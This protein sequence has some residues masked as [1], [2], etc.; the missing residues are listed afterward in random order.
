MKKPPT[1]NKATSDSQRGGTAANSFRTPSLMHNVRPDLTDDDSESVTE[2]QSSAVTHQTIETLIQTMKDSKASQIQKAW[3]AHSF[4]KNLDDSV[5]SRKVSQFKEKRA[6]KMIND[7]VGKYLQKKEQQ[8]EEA[9]S[10][11]A[12]KF[13]DLMVAQHQRRIF[14]ALRDH[15]LSKKYMRKTSKYSDTFMSSRAESPSDAESPSSTSLTTS[16]HRSILERTDWREIVPEEGKYVM[17]AKWHKQR[18]LARYF[19]FLALYKDDLL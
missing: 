8:K 14:K 11:K 6:A 17:A 12:T 9:N 2:S 5:H 4:R 10:Y 15:V 16:G 13:R 1:D 3:R 19:C 18:L 7:G